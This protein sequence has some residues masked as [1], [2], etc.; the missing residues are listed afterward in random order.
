M[1]TS[2]FTDAYKVLVNALVEARKEAGLSQTDLAERVGKWQKYV[3]TIETGSRRVDLVE[4]CALAKAMD[5]DPV[6]F[7]TEVYEKM[8]DKLDT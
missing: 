8:P 7:F 6:I 3:S 2:M 5:R 4:F 1:P